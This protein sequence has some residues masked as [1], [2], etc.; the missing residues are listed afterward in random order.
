MTTTTAHSSDAVRAR[1][2]TTIDGLWRI[3]ALVAV[4]GSATI[5]AA[6]AEGPPKAARRPERATRRSGKRYAVKVFD[7]DLSDV[8]SALAHFRAEGRVANRIGHAGVVNVLAEG[9]T[10]DGAPYLVM[11]LLEGETAQQRLQR[12]PQGLPVR[13]ALAIAEAVLDVLVA[14]HSR[15]IVHRDLKPDNV[16]L[17]R[18]GGVRVLDFGIARLADNPDRTMHGTVLGTPGYLPPEQARG[19]IDEIGPRSDL[20]TVGAMMYTLLTG[21]VL[22]EAPTLIAS[23]LRAQNDAAAP[24]TQLVPGVGDALAHALDGALAFN[25]ADRWM[26]ASAMLLAVR[27]AIEEV[28]SK[29]LAASCPG[30]AV[31]SLAPSAASQPREEHPVTMPG[32]G[33]IWRPVPW[34]AGFAAAAAA[35][36]VAA[37]VRVHPGPAVPASAPVAASRPVAVD[38]APPPEEPPPPPVE[39]PSLTPPVVDI[40]SLPAPPHAAASAKRAPVKPKAGEI[41]RTVDF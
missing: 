1:V 14:A 11:P 7:V 40:D 36:A 12:H 33:E 20:W 21:R 38:V 34:I 10:E 26:D 9:T 15:G 18:G 8:P 5:Y 35:L 3:D 13:E 24:A 17:E 25:P 39:A 22:H 41:V 37:F 23:V 2:G 27:A 32:P 19:K 6:T 4:G 28:R 29:E 31:D 30:V 16:F